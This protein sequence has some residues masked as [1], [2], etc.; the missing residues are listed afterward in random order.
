MCV[1]RLSNRLLI[2]MISSLLLHALFI[3]Q[4]S[5]KRFGKAGPEKS[6]IITDVEYIQA[7]AQLVHQPA[8]PRP[9][10][11]PKETVCTKAQASD[12]ILPPEAQAEPEDEDDGMA[13][14]DAGG[15]GGMFLPFYA[16]E[17]T[18]VFQTRSMPQYPP[19]ALKLGWTAKVVLEAYIDSEGV[20]RMVRIIKSG[21]D[22]FDREA[23]EAL[24]KSVF[25]PARVN[26]KPVPV[27][28]LVPYEFSLAA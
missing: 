25:K 5:L 27:K 7:S 8:K 20:V 18:P 11:R 12:P 4:F 22:L 15:Q 14:G 10:P 23:V 1:E 19:H 13:G 28:I 17:E 24:K 9:K 2:T 26:G 6:T 16:V 21:G 3:S